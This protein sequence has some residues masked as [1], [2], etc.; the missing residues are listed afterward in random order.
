MGLL[1]LATALCGCMKDTRQ[2]T[3]ATTE[4]DGWAAG[5]T[6]TLAIDT[7]TRTGTHGVELL[8]HTDGYAY[9][10]LALHVSMVQD[11]T[12]LYDEQLTIDLKQMKQ[13]SGI[14]QR[15]DYVVPLANMELSDTTH[16]TV[17]V[18]HRM[19]DTLLCGIGRI[20]IRIGSPARRPGEVVWQVEW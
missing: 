19:S 1:F 16:T 12:V 6:L 18:Y 11:T 17:N 15:C 9:T 13:A 5:D 10:N 20:G 2:L 14:A 8:L 4:P 3:F 7:L